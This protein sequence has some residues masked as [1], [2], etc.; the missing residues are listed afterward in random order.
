MRGLQQA[1]AAERN[2]GKVAFF[3]EPTDGP[4]GREIREHLKRPS[5]LNPER[6]L[7]LFFRDREHNLREHVAPALERG[8]LVIQDRYFY[9]TAAYQGRPDGV[10]PHA[11][12]ERSLAA[13]FPLPDLILFLHVPPG[14]AMARIRARSGL[15]ESFETRS[16]LEAIDSRYQSV[17]PDSAI[18]L[19]AT[20]APEQVLKDALDHIRR[21]QQAA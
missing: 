5:A 9:S 10:L 11:I 6:W 2:A 1:L 3:R 7:D 18:V 14:E 17:L 20:Q 16:Q 13:G 12:V 8:V 15:T 21:L 4:I 19:D